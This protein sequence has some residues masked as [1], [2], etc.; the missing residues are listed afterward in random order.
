MKYTFTVFTFT[1]TNNILSYKVGLNSL[2]K[3]K[4]Y[5]V[6][7]VTISKIYSKSIAIRYSF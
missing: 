7:F 4:T 6:C 3:L 5:T 2:K 1:K